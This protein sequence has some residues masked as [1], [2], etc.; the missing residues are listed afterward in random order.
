MIVVVDTSVWVSAFLNPT[1]FPARLMQAGKSGRFL[2]VSS[3][4]LL[5]ELREV[6]LRPWLMR[7]RQTTVQDVDAFMALVGTVVLLVS[8]LG[9]LRLCRDPDDDIVLETAVRGGADYLISRDED[10]RRD[11]DLT[12]QLGQ[13][14]VQTITVQHFLNLLETGTGGHSSDVRHRHPR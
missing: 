5:D 3:L 1:G 4:P 7:I 11:L 6:L 10:M 8:V 12:E 2:I 13:H 9:D 14:G